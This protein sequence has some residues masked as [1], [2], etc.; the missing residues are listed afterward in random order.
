MPD[1]FD[2]YREALVV[3]TNTVWDDEVRA[4]NLDAAEQTRLDAAL[5]AAPAEASHLDYVRLSVGFCRRI[6][7]TPADVARLRSKS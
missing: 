2:P 7:V 1:P 5:H 6:T 4:M 3:E